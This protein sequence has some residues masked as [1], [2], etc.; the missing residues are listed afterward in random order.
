M[1]LKLL[2]W[3]TVDGATLPWPKLA[4]DSGHFPESVVQQVRDW[5]ASMHYEMKNAK[6]TD[7]VVELNRAGSRVFYIGSANTPIQG[8]S[9]QRGTAEILLPLKPGERV[10]TGGIAAHFH[11][12]VARTTDGKV[13]L[14][15]RL[16]YEQ[17]AQV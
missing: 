9:F 15:P 12:L 8:Q 7:Q 5:L 1:A 10:G 2:R 14:G 13:I 11:F 4:D 17:V 16:R 6:P 3:F